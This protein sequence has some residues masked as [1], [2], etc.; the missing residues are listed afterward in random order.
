VFDAD[1][2][3]VGT[4]GGEGNQQEEGA[5]PPSVEDIARGY[6]EEVLQPQVLEDEPVETED[7]G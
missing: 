3:G 5:V 6:D 4:E 7:H 1:A 2:T